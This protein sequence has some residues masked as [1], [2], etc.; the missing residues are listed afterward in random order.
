MCSCCLPAVVC[1]SLVPFR[2][3]AAGKLTLVRIGLTC[4]DPA[5]KANEVVEGTRFAPFQ[6]R[7]S[8]VSDMMR[9]Q[10]GLILADKKWRVTH[11]LRVFNR[12][13][14]GVSYNGQL[15]E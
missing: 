12:K 9:L 6:R 1:Q 8:G 3:R 15:I 2:Q 4:D 5:G 11:P 10:A 13:G 7:N 14:R